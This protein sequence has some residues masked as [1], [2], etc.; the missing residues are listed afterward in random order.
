MMISAGQ[1]SGALPKQCPP[2]ITLFLG[3]HDLSHQTRALDKQIADLIAD[4]VCNL[5]LDFSDCPMVNSDGL[6]LLVEAR[7]RLID[8]GGSLVLRRVPT[9][10]ARLFQ[11]TRLDSILL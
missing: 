4:G 3:G 7:H 8:L 2:A 5:V 11:L 6:R 9:Y 10:V 1:P